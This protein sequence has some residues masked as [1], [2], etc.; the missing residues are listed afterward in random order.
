MAGFPLPDHLP[1]EPWND[2]SIPS[3][4]PFYQCSCE[5]FYSYKPLQGRSERCCN[6][7]KP[8]LLSHKI[9]WIVFAERTQFWFQLPPGKINR[10]KKYLK[11]YFEDQFKIIYVI[12]RKKINFYSGESSVEN[13]EKHRTKPKYS[14]IILFPLCC[15]HLLFVFFLLS[16]SVLLYI[17]RKKKH[18]RKH[19]GNILSMIVSSFA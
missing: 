5:Q 14:P 10:K 6:A 4:V 16:N 15:Q 8:S 11:E 18:K 2:L 1:A 17:L 3:P 7:T 13:T 12:N 9:L 19:D